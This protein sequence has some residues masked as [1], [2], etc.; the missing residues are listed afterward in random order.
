MTDTAVRTE[1]QRPAAR[2]DRG[3]LALLVGGLGG[4]LLL[5]V[6]AWL[7]GGLDMDVGQPG[8][9]L[10]LRGFH[11]DE[12]ADG[13]SYRWT[14]GITQV[15]APGLAAPAGCA[16]RWWP[17][18][19]PDAATSVP[20]TVLIDGRPSRHRS[21]VGS[22]A[23]PVL[24]AARDPGRRP[25]IVEFRTPTFRPAGDARDLG[26]IVDRLTIT[27]T[28]WSWSPLRLGQAGGCSWHALASLAAVW[29][30]PLRR[31]APSGLVGVVG[32]RAWRRARRSPGRGCWRAGVG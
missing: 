18:R 19:A 27:P 22:A 8:D 12:R 2:L 14:R 25:A 30:W 13:R 28:D 15:V 1:T 3:R 20:S 11:G 26:V 32:A 4:L 29:L 5:A 23:E 24:E 7:P 17:R 31:W 16:C 10:F 9:A 21:P 6:V